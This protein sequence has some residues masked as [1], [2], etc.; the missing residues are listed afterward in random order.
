MDLSSSSLTII[1]ILLSRM[2]SELFISGLV[3]FNSRISVWL[4]LMISGSVVLQ[5]NEVK[6][7]E[8]AQSCLTLCNP[9]DCSLPGSSVHGIFQAR[10]LEWIAISFSRGSSQPRDST[11]ASHIVDRSFT[12]WAT[13]KVPNWARY[14]QIAIEIAGI[15]D[16]TERDADGR[17]SIGRCFI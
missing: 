9:L 8:V 5:V 7:S 2:Y 10:V 14:A 17:V 11:P 6:W 13:R 1:S 15:R 12:A 3:F 4:L 16:G